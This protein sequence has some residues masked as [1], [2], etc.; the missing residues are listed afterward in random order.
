MARLPNPGGD[1]GVWGQVLNDFL[2]QA[3]TD[4]GT[5]K[6]DS[7]GGSQIQ[8]GA[9]TKTDVGLSNVDNTSDADKPIS[10]AAQ[11]ALDAKADASDVG[12]KVLLIQDAGSLP[13]GTPADVVVVL[14][15]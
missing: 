12:S 14:K 8:A 13:P 15:A 11:T 10:T 4:Q 2:S 9:V 5:L 6:A 3:H 7:V 1:Q